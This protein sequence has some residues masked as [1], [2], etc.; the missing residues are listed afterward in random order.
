MLAIQ[1]ERGRGA[2]GV[3]CKEADPQAHSA[4]Q[5]GPNF[6]K[7][8]CQ[9]WVVDPWFFF[10]HRKC[11]KPR[12][13]CPLPASSLRLPHCLI[14]PSMRRRPR[15][16]Q[17]RH[18]PPESLASTLTLNLGKQQEMAPGTDTVPDI[19]GEDTEFPPALG[20]NPGRCLCWKVLSN[21]QHTHSLS[22]SLPLK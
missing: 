5:Y 16:Q 6:S 3:A 20:F 12:T 19:H 10:E 18:L 15:G 13:P 2:R 1:Q 9:G 11:K 21:D 22:L 4:D 17:H 7:N 14:T 8:M